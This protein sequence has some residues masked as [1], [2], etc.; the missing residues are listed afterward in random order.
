MPLWSNFLMWEAGWLNREARWLNREAWWLNRETWWLNREAWSLNREVWWLNREAWWLNR[1]VWRLN[2]S[3]PDCCPAVPDLIPASPQPTADCQSPGGLPLGV[4]LGC[5]LTSVKGN[6]RENY[7]NEPLVRQKHIKKTKGKKILS[8]QICDTGIK[9]C[10][11]QKNPSGS[12][13]QARRSTSQFLQ[14]YGS[15]HM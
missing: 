12:R 14:L 15:D 5:R 11:K 6:R 2:S 8:Y 7:E 9:T 10:A 3:V 1:E 4:A 13:A